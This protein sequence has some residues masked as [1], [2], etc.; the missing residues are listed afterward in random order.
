MHSGLIVAGGRSTRFGDSDD[1]KSVVDVAGVPMIR[2]VADRLGP[3]ID[4][5]V[6]NCREEQIESIRDVLA[7]YGSP[8]RFAPDE[9]PDVG[10]VGGMATGL[11]A[12]EHEYAFVT[13][14]DM[15]LID[16]AFVAYLF[17]QAVGH[18][19]AVPQL[20]DRWLQTMHAVYRAQEMADA[21]EMALHT[22]ARRTVAP[23][24]DLD[25]II[26]DE[27]AVCEHSSLDT[28]KNVNTREELEQAVE[29]LR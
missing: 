11:R 25:Y 9:T 3:V 5:L 21:C 15:P 24:S 12:V 19:A 2:R 29:R 22:G 13:A 1:D 27:D 14:C 8:L 17:D 6:I 28:F 20:D 16:S 7:G 4:E 23:L 18:D 10:P 26:V